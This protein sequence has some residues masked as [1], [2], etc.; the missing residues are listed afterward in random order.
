MENFIFCAVNHPFLK[1]GFYW[2]RKLNKYLEVTLLGDIFL[3]FPSSTTS[4][5]WK[6]P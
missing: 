6:G 4:I 3:L 5:L 1:G 2:K